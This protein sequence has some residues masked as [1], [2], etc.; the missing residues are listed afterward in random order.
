MLR[1]PHGILCFSI[2]TFGF[3]VTPVISA[4]SQCS[5][6]VSPPNMPELTFL[7]NSRLPAAVMENIGTPVLVDQYV[8]DPNGNGAIMVSGHMHTLF[9]TPL[10]GFVSAAQDYEAHPDF[11]SR[12]VDAEILCSNNNSY[13]RTRQE[14]SFRVLG[15]GSDYEH[16][17]HYFITDEIASRGQFTMLWKLAESL[18]RKHTDIYGGWFFREIMFN[19]HPHTYV[20]YKT[21]SVFRETQLG[22]RTALNRFGERDMRNIILDLSAEAALR[23]R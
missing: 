19:G 3:F 9:A 22:L 2:L 16:E 18:D 17:L 5:A 4:Q 20:S 1:L 7:Q 23:S 12:F 13:V 14:L 11:L 10:H 21:T 8:G 15:F 6:P